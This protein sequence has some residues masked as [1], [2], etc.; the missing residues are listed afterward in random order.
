MLNKSTHSR[1]L[2]VLLFFFLLSVV[3]GILVDPDSTIIAGKYLV[4][5]FIIAIVGVLVFVI[6]IHIIAGIVSCIY[7][8]TIKRRSV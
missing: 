7:G 8:N 6:L 4:V 1:P 2:S 3:A 5:F